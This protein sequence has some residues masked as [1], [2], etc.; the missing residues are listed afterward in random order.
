MA[1][2]LRDREEDDII[3]SGK[4]QPFVFV[5]CAFRTF[6]SRTCIDRDNVICLDSQTVITILAS[7]INITRSI[8]SVIEETAVRLRV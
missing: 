2:L 5:Q 8:G 7:C 3:R 1:F 6:L 4:S